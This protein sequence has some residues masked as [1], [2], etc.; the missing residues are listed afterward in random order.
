MENQNNKLESGEEFLQVII[1]GNIKLPLFKNKNK[2]N[3]KAPDYVG[4]GICAYIQK[5][6]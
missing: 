2:T 5:K 3:P 4:N 6:K 1:L